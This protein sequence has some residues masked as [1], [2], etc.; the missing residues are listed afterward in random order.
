MNNTN[1]I[2]LGFYFPRDGKNHYSIAIKKYIKSIHKI[3]TPEHITKESMIFNVKYIQIFVGGPK[4]HSIIMKH[5]KEFKEFLNNTGIKCYVHT[6][7]A[8]NPWKNTYFLKQEAQNAKMVG[9]TGLVIHTNSMVVT[10]IKLKM[11][12]QIAVDNNLTIF[13][14][15]V[16]VLPRNALYRDIKD[17]KVFLARLNNY[18][19]LSMCFDTAHLW[20]QGIKNMNI[21]YKNLMLLKPKNLFFHLNDSA[22]PFAKG[23]DKHEVIGKGNIWR[24]NKGWKEFLL[25]LNRDGHPFVFEVSG[26]H[27]MV[28]EVLKR[29]FIVKK[30]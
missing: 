2:D 6:A 5:H 15:P 24:Q 12:N 29:E 14:E 9:A 10:N 26:K 11:I 25:N 1:N 30:D 8:H 28:A 18:P 27:N 21:W 22:R 23:L 7:Y 20:A 3:L 17:I 19:G 13:I 16:A 4:T